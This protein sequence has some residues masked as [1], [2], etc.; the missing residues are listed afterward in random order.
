MLLHVVITSTSSCDTS[1]RAE[2]NSSVGAQKPLAHHVHRPSG[3]RPTMRGDF[4]ERVAGFF[5]CDEN[6]TCDMRHRHR[7]S[8]RRRREEEGGGGGEEEG[9]RQCASISTGTQSRS[10]AFTLTRNQGRATTW[11]GAGLVAASS[12]SCRLQQQLQLVR[13]RCWVL[14][15]CV[16]ACRRSPARADER[17]W[18]A[19]ARPVRRLLANTWVCAKESR[20]STAR[21][22]SRFVRESGFFVGS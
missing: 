6:T 12:C 13:C 17:Q 16:S 1:V 14:T 11:S 9:Q 21:E 18:V 4:S 8:S 20:K 19:H 5:T 7:A 3:A 22:G 15:C 2:S 10:S